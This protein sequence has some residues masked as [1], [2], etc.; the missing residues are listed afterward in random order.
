MLYVS[1]TSRVQKGFLVFIGTKPLQL[2][3]EP[4]WIVDVRDREVNFDR[5]V[6]LVLRNGAHYKEVS[7]I[8]VHYKKL[9]LSDYK[10]FAI[11]S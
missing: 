11:R 10:H 2:C 1:P 8:S 3:N 6:E 5:K 7:A 4:R 9:C